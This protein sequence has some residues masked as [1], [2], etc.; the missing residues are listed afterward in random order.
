MKRKPEMMREAITMK[1]ERAEIRNEL[2]AFIETYLE[3]HG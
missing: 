1:A 3:I 2:A